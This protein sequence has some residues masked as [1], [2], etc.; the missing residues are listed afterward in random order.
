MHGQKN[1]WIH[2]YLAAKQGQLLPCGRLGLQY[3]VQ[4]LRIRRQTVSQATQ[5]EVR[6]LLQ[7]TLLGGSALTAAQVRMLQLSC[8]DR[9]AAQAAAAAAI[10]AAAAQHV[11]SH[12]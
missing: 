5:S 1:F 12:K 2:R 10:A 9:Q 11:C 6:Q 3:G 7:H 4:L 8:S